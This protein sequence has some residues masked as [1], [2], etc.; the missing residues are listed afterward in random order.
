M[1]FA[2]VGSEEEVEVDGR[3][4]RARVYPWGVVEVDNPQ[5]SDLSCL[6]RV[7]MEWVDLRFYLKGGVVTLTCAARMFMTL[8]RRHRI[9]C[10]RR[11]GLRSYQAL[12]TGKGE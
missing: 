2:V 9:R 8:R 6:Q 10:T 4:V 12:W 7:L 5:H 3:L 11:I 1:P